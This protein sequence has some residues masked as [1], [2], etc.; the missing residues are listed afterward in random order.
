MGFISF[1]SF[2]KALTFLEVSL[3]NV[4]YLCVCVLLLWVI[5]LYVSTLLAT[6]F[7]LLLCYLAVFL[8][9]FYM[10]IFLSC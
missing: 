9:E 2:L 5:V 6:S 10:Y 7:H 1:E 4:I 8:K 3:E